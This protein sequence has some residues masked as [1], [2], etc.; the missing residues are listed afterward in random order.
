MPQSLPTKRGSTWAPKAIKYREG[1]RPISCATTTIRQ[2]RF[3]C[4]PIR[5][6]KLTDSNVSLQNRLLRVCREWVLDEL[7]SRQ[8]EENPTVEEVQRNLLSQMGRL[9][10]LSPSKL[11]EVRL[12]EDVEQRDR[13]VRLLMIHAKKKKLREFPRDESECVRLLGQWL[14]HNTLPNGKDVKQRGIYQVLAVDG[15]DGLEAK[16]LKG[17]VSG[18]WH[19]ERRR[20]DYK[21]HSRAVRCMYNWIEA[22]LAISSLTGTDSACVVF[23]ALLT[24]Y[25]QG[26]SQ[27]L[28]DDEVAS[29]TKRAQWWVEEFLHRNVNYYKDVQ[30]VNKVLLNELGKVYTDNFDNWQDVGAE[31]LKNLCNK[32]LDDKMLT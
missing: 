13:F 4:A 16:H 32:R 27:L 28:M 20:P 9:M 1:L 21:K 7:Q 10:H 12:N 2:R 23:L 29:Q 5:N 26:L 19:P 18:L 11:P 31:L 24:C 25:R 8:R 22:S 30:K 6:V 15:F 17:Y 14:R 3:S